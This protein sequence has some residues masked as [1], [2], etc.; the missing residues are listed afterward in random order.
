VTT[1]DG[2]GGRTV[3]LVDVSA[4]MQTTDGP[5]NEQRF[6]LA[7]DAARAAVDRLH[8]GGLLHAND[9][10]TMIIGVGASPRVVQPFTASRQLL[11]RALATMKPVDE[12]GHL[13]EALALAQAWAAVPDPDA[14][15]GDGG[16]GVD[17]LRL[18]LFSDGG[19][20]DL[21]ASFDTLKQTLV[22]HQVGNAQTQN[23][24][25]ALVGGQRSSDDPSKIYPFVSLVHFGVSPTTV[26][27]R[28]AVDSVSVAVRRVEVPAGRVANGAFTPGRIDVLFPPVHALHQ[29]VIQAQLLPGDALQ[30]DDIAK[31]IVPSGQRGFVQLAG[32]MSDVLIRGVEAIG[33]EVVASDPDVIIASLT[34]TAELGR[35]PSLTFGVPGAS[36]MVQVNDWRGADQLV[37]ADPRHPVMRG[38]PLAGLRIEHAV[39]L[40]IDPS[41]RVLAHGT[42]GPLIV[43]WRE[44][45]VPRVHVGFLPEDSDWP[46]RE[47]FITFLVDAQ[48]W[49]AGR[50]D[51]RMR[52]VAGDTL[53]AALPADAESVSIEFKGQTVATVSPPD[54][55][56][57]AWGPAQHAGV[58]T[59]K[60]SSPN[61]QGEHRVAVGMPVMAEGDVRVAT[62]IQ[63]TELVQVQQARKRGVPLWPFAVVGAM[64]TL[65]VEWWVWTRR[66]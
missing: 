39:G 64:L 27:V 35:V 17:D 26:D 42:H 38:S 44:G 63:D 21:D 58:Y 14:V 12:P 7:I 6:A 2:R 53:S 36:S 5:N 43:A 23:T 47:D 59:L 22:L 8:P 19:L 32:T 24:A 48:A 16:S 55:S 34:T 40:S 10:H 45:G 25:I 31:S 50:S 4:S 41:V 49:L 61:T 57:M 60:W 52:F 46:Y 15:Q 28:L 62:G 66:Q 56:R 29:V 20:G 33:L 37:D 1:N 3:L 65:L 11:L 30:G 51:E 13:A 18:E 9:G 54:P